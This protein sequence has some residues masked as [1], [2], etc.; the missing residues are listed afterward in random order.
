MNIR[1]SEIKF[2]NLP[3][4]SKNSVGQVHVTSLNII[5]FFGKLEIRCRYP[6]RVHWVIHSLCNSSQ[7][8][9]E[10]QIH[11]ALPVQQALNEKKSNNF[12]CNKVEELAY[13]SLNFKPCS[14]LIKI[15]EQY[16]PRLQII[17]TQQFPVKQHTNFN[18]L[19]CSET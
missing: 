15:A 8:T 6:W 17:T 12:K 13:Y 3:V 18:T 9:H 19:P 1:N 10:M 11:Q 5:F 2:L 14:R 16:S 7:I 4:I